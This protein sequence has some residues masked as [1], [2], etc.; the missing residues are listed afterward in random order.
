MSAPSESHQPR[1]GAI[2][3]ARLVAFAAYALGLLAENIM[4]FERQVSLPLTAAVV[5]LWL[6]IAADYAMRINHA[7]S[8]VS[9][10]RGHLSY[11]IVLVSIVLVTSHNPWL[12]ALPLIV[13]FVLQLRETTT[14]HAVSFSLGLGL[15]MI[16][17]ATAG[18]VYAE[19]N[20]PESALREWPDAA[21]WAVATVIHLRGYRADT[22]LS[23]DGVVLAFVV[24]LAGL[25]VGAIIGAKII[26]WVIG[27]RAVQSADGAAEPPAEAPLPHRTETAA[28]SSVG[29]SSVASS[30]VGSASGSSTG[31]RRR[32]RRQSRRVVRSHRVGRARSSRTR[33]R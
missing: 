27:Q 18:V 29:S 5:V 15:F 7:T 1:Q 16:V 32:G 25:V 11:P 9:F 4:H 26:E 28:S 24:S 13:A 2:E 14:G 22:P 12:V 30:S 20:E 21:A 33:H 23:Q 31:P 3:L 19:R 10:V 17:L 8:R 6:V